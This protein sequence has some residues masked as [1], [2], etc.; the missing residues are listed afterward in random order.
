MPSMEL[1]R[2]ESFVLTIVMTN[3]SWRLGY[4]RSA[5]LDKLEH[6]WGCLSVH[7]T[8]CVR[9]PSL[10]QQGEQDAEPIR[11]AKEYSFSVKD[12]DYF[13]DLAVYRTYK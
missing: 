3:M 5:F 2:S 4:G 11:G 8:S 10:S 9:T 6:I 1:N 7:S 12:R 13:D